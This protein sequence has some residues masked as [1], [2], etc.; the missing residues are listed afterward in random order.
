MEK[1]FNTLLRSSRDYLT[2]KDFI[3][4]LWIKENFANKEVFAMNFERQVFAETFVSAKFF[5]FRESFY[6]LTL[7][8][9]CKGKIF[10]KC[11]RM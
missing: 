3:F 7:L 2:K 1:V 5:L 9:C 6:S 11:F 10:C 8:S 4:T